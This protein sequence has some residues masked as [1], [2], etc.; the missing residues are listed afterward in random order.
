M[1]VS[2]QRHPDLPLDPGDGHVELE[3][4]RGTSPSTSSRA[5]AHREARAA[6][7]QQ[8]DEAVDGGS[9]CPRVTAPLE[10]G[11][12][13]GPQA[14]ALRRAGDGHR[15]EVGRLEED[16]GGGVRDL[17]RRA[18]H[19]AGDPDRGILGV[20]DQAVLAGVADPAPG[21]SD[22]AGDAIE[23]LDR[24]AADGPGGRSVRDRGAGPGH[25]GGWAGPARASRSSTR[26][27]RC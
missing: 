16:L 27:R 6:L 17:R 18:A 3:S 8:F 5:V 9:R 1:A 7:G 21:L 25:R 12:G 2:A 23:R 19:D 20:A 15:G 24:L 13:L 22:G 10:A 14:Q 26:P 4:A 11:R